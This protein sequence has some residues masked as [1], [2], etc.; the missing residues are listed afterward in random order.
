MSRED[1]D[2][3]KRRGEG[4]EKGQLKRH[5]FSFR[6]RREGKKRCIVGVEVNQMKGWRGEKDFVLFC[7]Y[8]ERVEE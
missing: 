3:C 5:S 7:V 8:M 1:G 6:A 4:T 2:Y